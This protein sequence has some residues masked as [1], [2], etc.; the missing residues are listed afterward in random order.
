MDMVFTQGSFLAARIAGSPTRALLAPCPAGRDFRIK[1]PVRHWLMMTNDVYAVIGWF[2]LAVSECGFVFVAQW[3]SV[4]SLL[5]IR[6]SWSMSSLLF[7]DL[8]PDN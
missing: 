5:W 8:L 4:G 7:A 1:L 6:N 3:W 2:C